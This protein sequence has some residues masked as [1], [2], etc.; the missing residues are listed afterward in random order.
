[1]SVRELEKFHFDI[2][3]G[4]PM[5]CVGCPMSTVRWKLR[6]AEPQQWGQCLQN[7]DVKRVKLFRLFNFSDPLLHPNL[8]EFL[9]YIRKAPWK[10]DRVEISTTGQFFDEPKLIDTMKRQVLTHL[11][12]SCD[13]DCTQESYETLRPPSKWDKLWR[14]LIDVRRLRDKYSPRLYLGTRTICKDKEARKRWRN[15]LLRV[16]W[17]PKFRAWKNMP[18]SIDVPSGRETVVPSGVCVFM[19]KRKGRR[20]YVDADGTVVGCCQHPRALVLGSLEKQKYSK[21]LSGPQRI[22]ALHD[23]NH[24]RCEMEVCGKCE[25]K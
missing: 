18:E 2:V 13:G 6:F 3:H 17:V 11:F 23:L 7:V 4:C 5:A 20:L 19:D 10:A 9:P 25:V 1:M 15:A 16:G 14:F 8:P 21:I 24:I 22:Q 12:V